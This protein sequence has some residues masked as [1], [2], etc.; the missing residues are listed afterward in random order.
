MKE[1]NSYKNI[2][3][4]FRYAAHLLGMDEKIFIQKYVEQTTKGSK[5]ITELADI[6]ELPEVYPVTHCVTFRERNKK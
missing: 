5:S 1:S 4:S 6:M 3:P 2:V